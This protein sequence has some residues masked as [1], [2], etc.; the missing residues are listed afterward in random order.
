MEK[1]RNKEHVCMF[2]GHVKPMSSQFLKLSPVLWMSK[3]R[4]MNHQPM[5]LGVSEWSGVYTP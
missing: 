5:P 4:W 3:G 2:A 1:E